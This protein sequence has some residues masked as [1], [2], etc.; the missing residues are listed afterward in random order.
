MK[1]YTPTYLRQKRN[2]LSQQLKILEPIMLR[3]SLIERYK[4]CGKENCKCATTQGHGPKYYLSVSMPKS[5]PIMIYVSINIKTEIEAALNNHQ[6]VRQIIE[7]ISNINRELLT[8][9]KLL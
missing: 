4:K 6:K 2:R 8:R 3:G 9:K 1:Q 5:R 7:E